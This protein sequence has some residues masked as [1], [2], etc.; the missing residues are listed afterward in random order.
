MTQQ[1]QRVTDG[2]TPAQLEKEEIPGELEALEQ[3]SKYLF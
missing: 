1:G 3:V 2:P